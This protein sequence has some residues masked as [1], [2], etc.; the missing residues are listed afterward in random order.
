M[1]SF[2]HT[3]RSKEKNSETANDVIGNGILPNNMVLATSSFTSSHENLQDP[4]D[5]NKNIHHANLIKTTNS[6][7]SKA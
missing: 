5:T 1:L 7:F 3:K 6:F 2:S 4:G